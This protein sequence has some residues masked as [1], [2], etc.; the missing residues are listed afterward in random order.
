VDQIKMLAA[1]SGLS[2]AQLCI[3]VLL[4]TPGLTGCIVGARSARQ[5]SVIAS[6]GVDITDEQAAAVRQVIAA[7]DQD[8]A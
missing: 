3:G 5:G 6:L 4:H 2:T 8:L 1:E 7:L